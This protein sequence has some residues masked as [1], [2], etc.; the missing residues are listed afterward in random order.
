MRLRD[1][2]T[3]LTDLQGP[4]GP[5]ILQD[6]AAAG[7]WR[8]FPFSFSSGQ[9]IRLLQLSLAFDSPMGGGGVLESP[10]LPDLWTIGI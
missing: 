7:I 10:L 8:D 5:L 2:W 1:L 9:L 3:G 6:T 4:R